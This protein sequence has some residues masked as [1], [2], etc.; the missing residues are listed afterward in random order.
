MDIPTSV[1]SPHLDSAAESTPALVFLHGYGSN[2]QDLPG[3]ASWLPRHLPWVS[4]RAPLPMGPQ[5]AAWFPLTL[6]EEPAQSPADEATAALWDFLDDTLPSRP[7]IPVGF[8]QGGLMALQLLRTQPERVAAT[9][10]LAGFV[11]EE[12]NTADAALAERQPPVFW[13]RGDADQ[14][15]W[16]AA[17]ARTA[18][19]LEEH[20]DL[21]SKVYGGLGH[22]VNEQEL[23]DVTAFLHAHVS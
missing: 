21:T 1:A 6:P 11:T 5:A 7:L 16:P 10:V 19:W 12:G 2:E 23:R 22:S 15:I 17:V 14:V 3:L 18:T 20:A 13:G 4:V 9:V 8:S